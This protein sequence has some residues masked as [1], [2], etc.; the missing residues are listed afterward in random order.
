MQI[1]MKR[2]L[3]ELNV[4]ELEEYPVMMD[5]T[6]EEKCEYAKK[7]WRSFGMMGKLHNVIKYSHDSPQ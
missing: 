2:L 3:F 1:I 5:V 6:E 4:K 7:K